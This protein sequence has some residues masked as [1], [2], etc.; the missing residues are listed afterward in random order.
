MMTFISYIFL[1]LSLAAPIG[2]VNAAQ[3]EK[4]IKH[5]FLHAWILGIGSVLADIFYML[6]VFLGVGHF[7][8]IPIVKA[9]LWLF[10]FFILIYSGIEGLSN[11]GKVQISQQRETESLW[12]SFF[13]GFLMSISNPLTILFWLGIYG[14]VLAKT[15]TIYGVEDLL[16]YSSAIILGLVIWDITMAFVASSAKKFLSTKVLS[17]IAILSSLSLIGFGLYFGYEALKIIFTK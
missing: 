7:I 8:Q 6:A 9:F 4:G 5:G 3:M 17:I 14:S 2:P 15:A 16:I 1:G 10:G 12:K 13:T 11:A